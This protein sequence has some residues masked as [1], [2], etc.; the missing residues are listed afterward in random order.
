LYRAAALILAAVVVLFALRLAEEPVQVLR[1]PDVRPAPDAFETVGTS[2][3]EG[4]DVAS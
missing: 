4:R 1:K 2:R 3:T